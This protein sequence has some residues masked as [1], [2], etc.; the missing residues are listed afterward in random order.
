MVAHERGWNLKGVGDQARCADWLRTP[1]D[2]SG[3]VPV[4]RRALAG[5]ADHQASVGCSPAA[6]PSP[7]M[8]DGSKAS[9]LLGHAGRTSW[10]TDHIKP[11]SSRGMAVHTS[12]AVPSRDHRPW[13]RDRG[14]RPGHQTGGGAPRRAARPTQGRSPARWRPTSDTASL[15]HHV[16]QMRSHALP[17][18]TT[19]DLLDLSALS[20]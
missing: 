3:A 17:C 13:L 4:L 8:R 16:D 2:A 5:W 6:V 11:T 19:D 1:E 12:R 7:P 20:E 14:R 15:N 18:L 10:A 9:P